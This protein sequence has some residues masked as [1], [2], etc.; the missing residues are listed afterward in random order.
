MRRKDLEFIQTEDIMTHVFSFFSV[1]ELAS[2]NY[3]SSTFNLF[4]SA[5]S[6]W[7]FYVK[8]DFKLDVP[9][10]DQPKKYYHVTK[11]RLAQE[12]EAVACCWVSFELLS[13][14]SYS[15]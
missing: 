12:I 5:D 9:A 3:V 2:F 11:N 1:K 7:R 14:A 8:R 4:A 10:G 6:L 15:E 13:L